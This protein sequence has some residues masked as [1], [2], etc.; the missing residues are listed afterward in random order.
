MRSRDCELDAALLR[1]DRERGAAGSTLVARGRHLGAHLEAQHKP[2]HERRG[3]ELEPD[4]QEV[5]SEY[6]AAV[7]T[8]QE[9]GAAD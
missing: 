6:G 8:A 9:L 7:L 5:L 3:A 4:P 2:R 1:Y